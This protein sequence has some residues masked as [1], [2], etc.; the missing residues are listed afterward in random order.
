MLSDSLSTTGEKVSEKWATRQHDKGIPF[1]EVNSEDGSRSSLGVSPLG[2]AK[3]PQQW[4]LEQ[5]HVNTSYVM[6]KTA[7]TS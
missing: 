3:T 7:N 5:G 2:S 4:V 6:D 1:M